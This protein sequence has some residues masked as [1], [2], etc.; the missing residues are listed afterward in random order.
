MVQNDNQ[1]G[2]SKKY[3]AIVKI[4]NKADGTA[5][6]VKYRFNNLMKFAE[7]LDRNWQD[8]KWFNVYSNRGKNKKQQVTNFTNKQRPVKHYV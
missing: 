4:G 3:V 6:C 8:W 1:K 2:V 7:F 5:H